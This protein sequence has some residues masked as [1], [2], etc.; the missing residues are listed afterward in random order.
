MTGPALPETQFLLCERDDA[1]L[2]VWI[3]RPEVKNALS[4]EVFAELLAICDTV[5]RDDTLRGITLRGKGGTF[6]AGGDLR[7]FR[8]IFQGV[9]IDPASVA[10]SSRFFGHVYRAI[11][12]L[13]QV[14]VALVE[15]AAVAGGLGLMCVADVAIVTADTKFAMTETMLGISPAQIAPLVVRAVGI[16]AARRLMLTAARF[17]GAEAVALGLADQVVNDP[18]ELAAAEGA[19]RCA[20]L[21]CAPQA[22]AVTKA[23][24][25]APALDDDA[26]IARAA[27]AYT[28]CMLGPEG[29]EG[30]AAFFDK[31][32]PFWT[33]P[34]DR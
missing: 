20:V 7:M 30:V 9:D 28:G 19:I 5:R 11:D 23:L 32:R 29:R 8:D 21:R 22:N 10:A 13:P 2:T 14:V 6:S 4:Q 12:T 3:N 17:S 25:L 26:T 15:G 31:R 16:K 34:N 33:G 1:W 18:L 24:L 27:D